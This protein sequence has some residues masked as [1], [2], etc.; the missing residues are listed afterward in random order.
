MG[1]MTAMGGAMTG[2]VTGVL[3]L[4][5]LY[6]IIKV[7][8]GVLVLHFGKQYAKRGEEEENP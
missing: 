1:P 2:M 6:G 4:P 7:V 8:A 5:A 3:W